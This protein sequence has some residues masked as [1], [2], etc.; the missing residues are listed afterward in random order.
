M[1]FDWPEET[2]RYRPVGGFCSSKP[3]RQKKSRARSIPVVP[4]GRQQPSAKKPKV[5]PI[6]EDRIMCQR[7]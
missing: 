5:D 7:A 1:D 6:R 2:V 4:A 3:V